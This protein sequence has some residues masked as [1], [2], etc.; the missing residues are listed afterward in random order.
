MFAE[1]K[2]TDEAKAGGFDSWAR[3][4]PAS[5]TVLLALMGSVVTLALLFQ[6]GYS[7]VLYQG[8]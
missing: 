7:F 5:F 2:T 6:K 8:F 4:H 1:K 3:A